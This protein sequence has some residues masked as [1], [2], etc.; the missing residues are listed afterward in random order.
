MSKKKKKNEEDGTAQNQEVRTIINNH[1][2][3]EAALKQEIKSLNEKIE[4]LAEKVRL[5]HQL[6]NEN[7]RLQEHHDILAAKVVEKDTIIST[8]EILNT[9][10]EEFE[11]STASKA[12]PNKETRSLKSII[13]TPDQHQPSYKTRYDRNKYLDLSKLQVGQKLQKW[14][15]RNKRS[16]LC[17][18]PT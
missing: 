14:S 12:S 3:T 13:I 8:L 2:N 16:R 5:V 10:I 18:Y 1:K 7:R 9:R 15:C 11:K 6:S 4:L 17:S